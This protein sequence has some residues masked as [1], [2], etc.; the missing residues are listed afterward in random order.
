MRISTKYF[1]LGIVLLACAGLRLLA[2]MPT[3]P[4]SVSRV[5]PPGVKRGSTATLTLEGRSL[6]GARSV[7]FDAPGLTGKILNIRDLPEE[8][9]AIRIG[10][11]LGA[12]I[13]QGLKQEVR[14][15]VSVGPGVEVGVHNFRVQTPRGTSNLAALDVGALP[16]IQEVEPN[17]SPTEAQRVELPATLVGTMGWPGDVDSYSFDGKAGEELVFQVVAASLGSQLESVLV[18]RDS[19]GK[20]LARVGDYSRKADAVLTAKLP[21]DGKYTISVSDVEKKGGMDYFYRL[22]AGA[23]PYVTEVFPLGVRA[24]ESSEVWV[25]GVN[26]GQ[27]QKVPVQAPRS[28]AGAWEKFPLRVKT[29][30]GESL[31]K[32]MLAVGEGPEVMESEPNDS[33]AKAQKVTIPVTINGRIDNGKTAGPTDEDYYRFEAKKGEHLLIDVEAARLESP[34]DS[35]AEVL[36]ANGE[37][38]PSA[39]VRS[40]VETAL[41]LSDR[42]SKTMGFR[43]VSL[44]GIHPRDYLMIG[45]ELLQITLIPEQPDDDLRVRGF[46]GERAPLL[47]TSPQAH[48]INAPVYRV[49]I[50]EPGKEF[51]PNGLPVFHLTYRNDDGGP[52]YGQDSRLDFVAPQDAEYLLHIK[53]VRGLQGED[54]AYRLTVREAKPDFTLA[55]QPANP[56]VPRGGRLPITVEADR[57]AGYEGPIEIQVKGLP[58]GVTASPATIFAGQYSTVVVL[59]TGP[60]AALSENAL[61]F[62]VVGRATL[63]GR[64]LIRAAGAMEPLRVASVMPPPDVLVTTEPHEVVLEA[65][66]RSSL[67]LRVERK[68]GFK[69][70]LLFNV[71]NLPPGVYVAD[72]GFT[73]V[74]VT[75][76]EN[77]RTLVLRAEDWVSSIDQPIYLVGTV[78]SSSSTQHSSPPFILKVRSKKQVASA[79]QE[80]GRSSR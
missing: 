12:K 23:L 64:E 40:L 70:R 77:S 42:D 51:P 8:E 78:E 53:D 80:P 69:G 49:K 37:E 2:Q 74:I 73:G 72:I 39:T 21:S 63:D 27:V 13:P 24:G 45:D 48:A 34:L 6:T 75:E 29:P 22:N 30:Q 15:E 61:P 18:L 20:E 33:P 62:Q 9:K 4:P 66:Q 7:L 52:G 67:T 3:I 50:F 55:A 68:N 11:D 35:V 26:L 41:T 57:R 38:I 1:V 43:T 47:N 31:N 54:F 71:M 5:T 44:T 19:M 10:V 28:S 36:D 58:P 65:G 60:D 17:D 32:V 16:E 25:K 56:N 46:R 14:L 59:A 76:N 79:G